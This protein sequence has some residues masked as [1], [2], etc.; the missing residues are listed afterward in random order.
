MNWKDNSCA[1]DTIFTIYLYL[2]HSF[3]CQILKQRFAMDP[4]LIEYQFTLTDPYNFENVAEY[5]ERVKPSIERWQGVL[6]SQINETVMKTKEEYS[7]RTIKSIQSMYGF[8]C[9]TNQADYTQQLLTINYTVTH[10][11]V[12]NC[13][14]IPDPNLESSRTMATISLDED[15]TKTNNIQSSI[16]SHFEKRIKVCAQCGVKTH[17]VRVNTNL[18]LIINISREIETK[19]SKLSIYLDDT[20]THNNAEYYL[21]AVAYF[22]E[23]HYI[24][25]IKFQDKNYLY[26]GIIDQGK[27]QELPNQSRFP[28]K[29]HVDGVKTYFGTSFF[30][31]IKKIELVQTHDIFR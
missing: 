20:I 27:L 30:Y 10:N 3:T 18:P 19:K 14:I 23:H 12:N 29:Y 26:D 11:C 21:F 2:Y 13:V 4:R 22:N 25:M 31:R 15:L 24:S 6:V 7:D 1:T 17:T 16:D 8:L 28:S 5:K 9:P